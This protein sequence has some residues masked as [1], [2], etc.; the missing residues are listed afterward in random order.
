MAETQ[1]PLAHHVA[2][3]AQLGQVLGHQLE[4]GGEARPN[5]WMYH[6]VLP[7]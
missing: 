2:A 6:S 5:T 4:P 1:V 7:P 3:V